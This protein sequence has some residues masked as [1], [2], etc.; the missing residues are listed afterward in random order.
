[1]KEMSDHLNHSL[2][3][4][5]CMWVF[6]RIDEVLVDAFG[7]G[8]LSLILHTG[9]DKGGQVHMR[10]AVVL[11]FIVDELVDGSRAVAFF[12]DLRKARIHRR[13]PLDASLSCCCF[14]MLGLWKRVQQSLTKQS[15]AS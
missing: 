12:R 11:Q 10:L 6:R 5:F 2:V 9:S 15:I 1:M 3:N 4:H 14:G 13:L 7:G 8:L